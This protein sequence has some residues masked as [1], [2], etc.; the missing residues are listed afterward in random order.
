MSKINLNDSGR[1][2][3][4]GSTEDV[5]STATTGG[6]LSIAGGIGIAKSLRA[7]GYIY[8]PSS[9]TTVPTAGMYCRFPNSNTYN[10][11]HF[12]LSSASTGSNRFSIYNQTAA[13]EILSV[14]V[15]KTNNNGVG[16][17]LPY[18]TPPQYDLEVVGS[19]KANTI[20]MADATA[21][22]TLSMW[23][24]TTA[25]TIAVQS[26]FYQQIGKWFMFTFT[27]V[28]SSRNGATGGGVSV[29]GF[30]V[31]F[32]A[33]PRPAQAVTVSSFS[34]LTGQLVN[35]LALD[36]S[37]SIGFYK[38]IANSGAQLIPEDL[39]STDSGAMYVSGLVYL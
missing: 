24:G 22:P 13:K 29:Y 18:N 12:G 4:S 16:I 33:N 25:F 34:T 14:W 5:S 19:L 20:A 2:I 23:N 38:Q 32:P 21:M 30:P 6:A 15:D 9:I 36:N 1:L 10:I 7:D 28:W 8:L 35:G 3:L 11:C 37:T 39:P 17:N 27:L 26:G 31:T